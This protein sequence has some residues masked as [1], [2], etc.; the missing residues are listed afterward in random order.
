MARLS[1][2]CAL[3]RLSD[4]VTLAQW[5][6][7]PEAKYFCQIKTRCFLY[8]YEEI[9]F[10]S[11]VTFYILPVISHFVC[12]ARYFCCFVFVSMCFLKGCADCLFVA[13]FSARFDLWILLISTFFPFKPIYFLWLL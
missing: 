2:E 7:W 12:I 4:F 6:G 5:G 9:T 10:L 13:L 8:L 11:R 3:R 1:F